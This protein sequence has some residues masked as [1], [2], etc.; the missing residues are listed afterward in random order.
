[1]RGQS[2]DYD[3]WAADTKD[4]S[5]SWK[6]MLELFKSQEHYHGC[7]GEFHGKDGEWTVSNQRLHW[8]I[9][10]LFKEAAIEYG[11]PEV[12]S[13]ACAMNSFYTTLL[14]SLLYPPVD[15]RF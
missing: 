10:D 5:W 12:S 7:A 14:I 1:M 13:S 3:G 2:H 4:E 11:I 8:E 6:H 9:L 15:E